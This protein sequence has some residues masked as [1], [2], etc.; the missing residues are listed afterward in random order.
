M[1]A[2][3]AVAALMLG[4]AAPAGAAQDGINVTTGFLSGPAAAAQTEGFVDQLHPAWVRVFLDWYSI[5]PSP[6][7]YDQNQLAEYR[8]FF[9]ALPPGTKVDVTVS[10]S[11]AWANGGSSNP[12]T[13]PVNDQSFAGF[14]TYLANAF[15]SSVSAWEIWNEEDVTQ[16]WI[17]TPAQYASLLKAADSAIKA[18]N[19]NATVILGGLTANDYPF[20]SSVYAAGG[21]SGFDAVALHTDDACSLTSPYAF[22]FNPGTQVINRW[23]FLGF[24]TVH[25]V[26]AANGDSAKPI[27]M[28]EFGWSTTKTECN[29]GSSAGKKLGGVS[30]QTQATFMQQAYHC[31]AQP[32]Y[33][34]VAAAMW[35]DLGDSPTLNDFY[36][37]YGLV[38][39]ALKPKPAFQALAQE[40]TSG[41]QLTGPCGNFAGPTLHLINPTNG[42]S[43]SGR[44]MLRVSATVNGGAPGDRVFQ[45]AV[46]HDGKTILNFNRFDAHYARGTLSG[47]INWMG[48]RSL[49]LGP[50]TISAVA[51]NANGVTSKITVTVDHVA[52][53]HHKHH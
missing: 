4:A 2:T 12:A 44:L 25:G 18:V 20:L 47:Q 40:S 24:T 37:R 8:A 6:G 30:P 53:H 50:H 45:I 14:L 49:S 21:G 39:T 42:E 35:F 15:G 51:M 7:T 3:V 34:Y 27:Y 13:P 1:L 5:E 46:Q 52:G 31:L 11:P 41:D 9:A 28:T 26:M 43:Y 16:N 38:T 36:G 10:G 17:G 48:A 23:S 22:A 29:A 32:Q 33:S 19:P